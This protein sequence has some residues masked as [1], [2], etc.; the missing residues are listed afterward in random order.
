[1]YC[2]ATPLLLLGQWSGPCKGLFLL[3]SLLRRYAALLF[4]KKKESR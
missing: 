3:L 1:M 4:E 2:T